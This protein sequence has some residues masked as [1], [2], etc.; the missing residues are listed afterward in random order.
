MKKLLSVIFVLLF[1]VF[2]TVVGCKKEGPA[3]ADT[4]GEK[5]SADASAQNVVPAKEIAKDG[6]FIAY[7]N[8]TVL[9]KKTGLMWAAKDNGSDVNWDNAKKYCESYRG[10]G[11]A[12]WRMPTQ[13]ELEGLYDGT[14]PYKTDCGFDVHLTKLIRFTCIFAWASD[15][16]GSAEAASFYFG[17]DGGNAFMV[18]K[19]TTKNYRTL[20]VR[21][22]K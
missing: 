5:A 15:T 3:P 18:K 16:F 11:Y 14:K 1:V 6:N 9:D 12:N 4:T 7:D 21:S 19:S 10:G 8:G 2:F 13:N 17:P 20:P 22:N